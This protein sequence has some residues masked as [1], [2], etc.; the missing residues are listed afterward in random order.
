MAYLALDENGNLVADSGYKPKKK[1]QNQVS[2]PKPKEGEYSAFKASSYNLPP[3]IN[4]SKQKYNS[5]N[6]ALN[7]LS[8]FSNNEIN[9]ALKEAKNQSSN[10]KKQVYNLA[11]E[12]NIETS[13]NKNIV[14][15]LGEYRQESLKQNYKNYNLP[16][17]ITP[18]TLAEQTDKKYNENKEKFDK[19]VKTNDKYKEYEDYAYRA[20]PLL[21]ETKNQR[22][23]FSKKTNFIDK[24]IAP[25]IGGTSNALNNTF[26]P[27]SNTYK[28]ANGEI[29]RNSTKSDL[30]AQRVMSEVK[31]NDWLGKI[32]SSAT[33]S[34]GNM[35]PSIVAGAINPIL[36]ATIMGGN[37]YKNAYN[38][39]LKEG[40][41]KEQANRYATANTT[42]ELG[43][44]KALGGMTSVIGKSGVSDV[45]SKSL[46]KVISSKATRDILAD[47]GSEFLEE[48]L[49]EIIDPVVRN[50]TLN[51]NNEF[52]PF[53]KEALIAGISGSLN[54]GI[55]NYPKFKYDKNREKIYTKEN[56]TNLI[57]NQSQNNLENSVVNST[58]NNTI[59]KNNMNLPKVNRN[60]N[61]RNLDENLIKEIANKTYE[62]NENKSDIEFVNI[63]DILP[64]KNNGGFRTKEQIND[65]ENNIRQNGM[66][67]PIEL[68]K[69]AD[70]STSIY[71]GNH[72]L[73][74]AQKIGLTEIPVKFINSSIDSL[75]DIR[76]NYLEGDYVDE[77][78]TESTERII[79]NNERKQ[80]IGAGSNINSI[81]SN[82]EKTLQNDDRIYSSLV[83]HNNRPSS[84]TIRTG[85]NKGR[86][87]ASN[88]V[89]TSELSRENKELKNSSFNLPTAKDVKQLKNKDINLPLENKIE[90]KNYL[91][92]TE[93][94]E[95]NELQNMP[96][97][98]DKKQRSRLD[99]LL[100]KQEG[101]KDRLNIKLP[102]LRQVKATEIENKVKHALQNRSY[103]TTNDA[104]KTAQQF[105]NF[106]RFEKKNF[107]E[108]LMRFSG[109]SKNELQTAKTY[110]DVKNIIKKYANREITF[111]NEELATIKQEIKKYK[112]KVDDYI[113]SNIDYNAFRKQNFGKLKLGDEGI[114][115][116]S[117]WQELSSMYPQYFDRNVINEFD[118][119]NN[120]SDFM[121]QSFKV[122]ENYT[123]SDSEINNVTN[124]VF[125]KLLTNSLNNDEINIIQ[126]NLEDKY[127]IRTRAMVQQELLD[128]MNIKIEDLDVGKDIGNIAYQRTDPIRLNEK[129]FGAKIGQKI[130]DATINQTKHNEAER[131]R[132]LN[133]EREE[134]KALNIKAYSKESAAVQ[135]YAEKSYIGEDGKKHNYGDLDLINE[136]TNIKT[137]EKIKKAAKV[138]RNKYD[139]YID[140]INEV[141]TSLGYNA[142][143][144]RQDYMHHFQELDS[145]FAEWGL[146][147]SNIND[148]N[149]PT[150]INGLTEQFKPSKNYFAAAMER[151]GMKTKYDAITGIDKY[152]E[153]A[154]NLIYHTKDIQRYRALSKLIRET[155]GQQHGMD[156]MNKFTSEQFNQRLEDIYNGK[157][158][159]YVVWLDEQAN[160]LAGKKGTIDRSAERILGRKVYTILDT[161]KKQVG[162]NMTGFNVRSALT[163]F[164]SAIQ[165]ASKTN[166]IAFLKGTIS[167]FKNIIHNDGLIYKSDFLTSRFGSNQ[168]SQKKWQKASNA[169]QIFMSGSDYFTANQIWR[170]KY[171]ESLSKGMSE[172]QAIKN[173]D[174]FSSRI[175]GDR[176][177]GTTAEIFNS[178]TLG[179][180]TQFQLEVNNQWS[181][182]IHDNK[183]DIQTGNKTKMATFFQLGQLAAASY[184]FNNLMKSLTGSSVMFDP[185][186]MLK[187]LIGAD[188]EDEE[189]SLDTR[190]FEVFGDFMDNVPMASVFTGGRVPISE[191][192]TGVSTAFKK[193]TNQKDKYGNDITYN[194]IKN[195]MISSAFYWLLPTGYG[196]IKKTVK[197]NSMYDKKLHLPGSYTDSGNLRFNADDSI[198]GK[199]KAVLFG[200]YSSEEAQKYIDS[201]YKS[202]NKNHL[203]EMRKLKM[204]ASEYRNYRNGLSNSGTKNEDK[205]NYI[206]SLN[207]SDE[208]K[209]IMASNVLKKD[210]N[211]KDYN[212]Y[213]SYEEYNYVLKNP[214]KYSTITQIAKYDKY[215]EYKKELEDIRKTSPNKKTD[216]IN[217]I[218]KLKLSIPQKAMFI[219][220]YYSS[221]NEYNAQIV[222]YIN[223]QKINKKEKESILKELGFTIRDGRVYW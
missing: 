45:I 105:I 126:T 53:T 134:I 138:L 118:M 94:S 41:T 37:T 87:N 153:G 34:L 141:I 75:S 19:I 95:L 178:K 78:T 66:T 169:G 162:S 38:E 29:V 156:N 179:L 139:T 132:F 100:N 49:Q 6:D 28:L 116:D 77:N 76:Y 59:N 68:I 137:Q 9:N 69:K 117:A 142:I 170:S 195:D 208:N 133:K 175:M 211:I 106:D 47:V 171:Y 122:T 12:M 111:I 113:K 201:G 145:K 55:S 27:T 147:L 166:K 148:E 191:A 174:D 223:S 8:S 144:K 181:S 218:N 71:N 152:L 67:H 84:D 56:V 198:S 194:D 177:K 7:S 131:T 193:F 220:Q 129:V 127:N 115:I 101:K 202:I 57:N 200:Q 70:G 163:N 48:Y 107:K 15:G 104:T 5:Y 209:S 98:L 216:T 54:A 143:P 44:G 155:Y 125:D 31:D 22:E 187:K 88:G 154:S 33:Y 213:S 99:Y 135:K 73:E 189:K 165:G 176:S 10:Y 168:L 30:N 17:R 190:A 42:L 158:S 183:I 40:Y 112:I 50:I 61:Q 2:L 23:A 85:D 172:K 60:S 72:R 119:L 222:T 130:N 196:Q 180:F 13:N 24:I 96:F 160:S 1:K 16:K 149:L 35:T 103:K 167:T 207:V 199:I 82:R 192:F 108:E 25:F 114:S 128:E 97:D 32:Y 74:V 182:M 219:K 79:R 39:S 124:R 36:G 80:N 136:F 109:K 58:V 91:S 210:I 151:K 11:D 52:K 93:Q 120:L 110:Q 204:T 205:L 46:S 64:L 21:E 214:E 161:A 18:T 20:V 173:A 83:G 203:E 221:F 3:V 90:N 188:D 212:K 121:N 164:A 206:N 102:E 4:V 159:K 81:L 217:Y 157:L 186:D 89:D 63:Y 185:I 86:S 14:K 146:P 140:N 92:S 215:Q 26:L 51:E 197:G 62:I 184:L 150:D 43:L 123:L 65:L